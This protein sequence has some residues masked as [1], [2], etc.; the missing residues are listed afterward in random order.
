MYNDIENEIEN[1]FLVE[2]L[3]TKCIHADPPIKEGK[4]NPSI[5]FHMVFMARS[6]A[7]GCIGRMAIVM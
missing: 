7:L 1:D 2:L 3:R 4:E 6:I 5:A